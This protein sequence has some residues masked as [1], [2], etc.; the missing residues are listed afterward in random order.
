MTENN[1]KLQKPDIFSQNPQISQ[2]ALLAAIVESSDDAIVSKT[3]DGII[4]SWNKGAEKLFGYSAEEMIGKSINTIIPDYLSYEEPLICS[5][6][7][8]GTKINHFETIR[9]HKSG[10]EIKV[11]LS[12]SPIQNE[13]GEIIGASKIARDISEQKKFEAD[14]RENKM[15]LSL[16]MQSSKMGAWERDIIEDSVRWSAE[17]EKIFGIEPGGFDQTRSGFYELI[18]EDDRERVREEVNKAIGEKRSYT[19]EFRFVHKDG[20]IRWMEGRGQALYSKDGLPEKVYGIGIDITDRKLAEENLRQNEERYRTLFNSIDAGFC[21]IEMIFDEQNKPI[22]YRFIETNPMFEKQTGLINPVGKTARE[23]VPDL[24]PHWFEIYGNIAITGEQTRFVNESEAMNRSF[25]VYGLRLGDQ[26]SRK[27]AVIFNDITEKIRSERNLIESEIRFRGLQQA[28][29]DGF[30]IFESMR[31]ET[32]KIYDFKWIYVN[33]AAEKIVMRKEYELVGKLLLE[34]MPGNREE[35]LFDAFK[36]VVETGNLW[37]KEFYYSHEQLDNHFLS[38]AV[39]VNDGFAVAFSDISERKKIELEREQLLLSEKEARREA[40]AA[41]NAKDEFLSVLSHELR[42]PL[43]AILGWTR[44][45]KTGLLDEERKIQAVETI[46]RNT[47]LQHNL[48]EDLLDVS[49]IISGKMLIEEAEI[50]FI[51]TVKSAMEMIRSLA[52]TKNIQLS[53]ETTEKTAIVSGDSTRLQ[54]IVTNLVN[55]AVKFTPENGSVKLSLTKLKQSVLLIVEDS[56]IGISEEILPHIFD[57]FRQADSTTKRQH[58]G[59]GLGLTIVRHLAELHGGKVEA[60]SNGLN[61]G[62]SFSFEMPLAEKD[63]WLTGNDEKSENNT[64]YNEI[65]PFLDGKSILLVDDEIDGII[66]I[67][68]MLEKYGAKTIYLNSGKEALDILADTSFDLLISDIGMPEMDGYTFIIKIRETAKN[69]MIPAIALTAYA[70]A[71][72]RQRALYS[73]FQQHLAK[74]INFDLLLNTIAAMLSLQNENR[75]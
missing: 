60:K 45:M 18:Y 1:N 47:K 30:M 20:S 23:L 32:G 63:Y 31:D 34:E 3:L 6:I 26:K 35:G 65:V 53:F 16:A 41:N 37:Q 14:L 28:T 29:P 10:S 69:R 17:L 72:D 51:E 48:I 52:E 19:I 4:L 56:G 33:P 73:G 54:Q 62:S 59:L 58:S 57:R 75:N 44:L 13:Q 55:N 5:K 22:D 9:K 70:G 67:Q 27:V 50:D 61:K 11:S 49:R 21:I 40:E 71:D 25:D 2:I 7:K 38:T 39:K 24:E 8:S 12:V 66:P 15:M 42:T 74:P 68:M 36:E 43:N 46:E 64:E